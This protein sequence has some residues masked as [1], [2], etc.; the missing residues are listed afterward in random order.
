MA[1]VPEVDVLPN[2]V[3]GHERTALPAS[4]DDREH[5]VA[6]RGTQGPGIQLPHLEAIQAAF[7]LSARHRAGLPTAMIF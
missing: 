1:A 2:L 7:G 5:L 6:A 4:V 3:P